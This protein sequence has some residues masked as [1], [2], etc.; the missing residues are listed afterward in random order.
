L[1]EGTEGLTFS[2]HFCF[3]ISH[4]FLNETFQVQGDERSEPLAD[5]Q[6]IAFAI[7]SIFNV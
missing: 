5:G 2:Y 1:R 6:L 4:K 3:Y 7:M